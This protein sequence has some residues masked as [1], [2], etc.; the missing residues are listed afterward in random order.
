MK[1]LTVFTPTYNRAHTI[2][3]TYDSLLRQTC[4]DFEWLVIDD[5]STDNTRLLVEQ[6]I[7][8][9]RVPIRYIH[10]ENGGLHTG[11]NVALANINTELCICCDSDDFLPDDA[12]EII[13]K[14]WASID[15]KEHIAGIIG[16]DFFLNNT[17]IGGRFEKI[18]NFHIYE[19]TGFHHGDTKIVCRTEIMK[20][21]VPMP[22][23]SGEKNFNPIYFYVQ[24]D[25]DYKFHLI[26]ENLCYVDYQPAGMS[27]NIFNQYK[28][29]PQSF[30]EL[31]RLYM[32]MP[33]YSFKT[34]FRNAIHYISSCIFARQ[35]NC[36]INSPRPVLCALAVPFGIIL[37]MYV[38]YRTRKK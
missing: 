4:K 31:R 9:K 19:M 28:N 24:I 14:T 2:Y 33:Y 38:R 20:S 11:Y 17:P 8:E 29:S 25:K 21:F 36:I 1:T 26:N 7:N 23:F 13:T 27:A 3:R 34:N 15:A 18:G 35:Y 30:A 16:L 5:G 22:V 12:V 6:W 32:S 37:N 10:K